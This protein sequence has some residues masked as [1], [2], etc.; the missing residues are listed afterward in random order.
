MG[1]KFEDIKVRAYTDSG[2]W[3]IGWGD[4]TSSMHYQLWE[5]AGVL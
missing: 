3:L 5:M 4:C 2:V 1:F